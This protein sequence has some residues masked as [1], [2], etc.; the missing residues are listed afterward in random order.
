[1]RTFVQAHFAKFL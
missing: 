1:M